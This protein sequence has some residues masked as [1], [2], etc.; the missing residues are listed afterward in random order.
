MQIYRSFF[1]PLLLLAV[2]IFSGCEMLG[3][4][5]DSSD[6]SSGADYIGTW[7]GNDGDGWQ[8]I[9]ITDSSFTTK[10]SNYSDMNPTLYAEKGTYTVSGDQMTVNRTYIW[11]YE[12]DDYNNDGYVDESEWYSDPY[13]YT[14]TYSVSNDTFT[15]DM[16]GEILQY[17]RQ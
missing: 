16:G 17:T 7:L 5:Y 13:S 15:V 6:T 8:Q 3:L 9:V 4:S 2:W 10:F 14:V 1:I 12:L 11:E